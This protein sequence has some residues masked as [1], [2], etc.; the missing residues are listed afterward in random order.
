MD[1]GGA[2]TYFLCLFY[3]AVYTVNYF[4][5]T[6]P[7]FVGFLN[8]SKVLFTPFKAYPELRDPGPTADRAYFFYLFTLIGA[9]YIFPS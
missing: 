3:R 6:R 7:S 2:S 9:L 4:I 8:K 5:L 1:D